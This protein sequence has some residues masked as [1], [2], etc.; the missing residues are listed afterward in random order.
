M[1]QAEALP[2]RAEAAASSPFCAASLP[3]A[4]LTHAHTR[5]HMLT[6]F[7]CWRACFQN[8]QSPCCTH[9]QTVTLTIRILPHGCSHL[10]YTHYP[11]PLKS[12]GVWVK[13]QLTCQLRETPGLVTGPARAGWIIFLGE[14]EVGA[15]CWELR[16]PGTDARFWLHGGGGGKGQLNAPQPQRRPGNS[17]SWYLWDQ[18]S[19]ADG[20]RRGGTAAVCDPNTFKDR[21][22]PSNGRTSII[23]HLRL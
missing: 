17:S 11:R 22:P 9:C 1:F 2:T 3:T 5:G 8:H 16:N 10:P 6:P 13:S 23:R 15:G 4:T 20:G 7:T 18:V 21:T 19:P 12:L 14:G